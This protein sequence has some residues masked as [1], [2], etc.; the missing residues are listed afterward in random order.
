LALLCMGASGGGCAPSATE[1]SVDGA[2]E[3]MSVDERLLEAQA[4]L[5]KHDVESAQ[6][7]YADII[8]TNDEPPGAAY[9]GKALTDLLLLPGSQAASNVLVD[10]LGATSGIDANDALYAEEGFLYWQV[11]GVP[12]SDDGSYP[13]IRSL[14]S[15]E[16]PWSQDNL[17]SL[18]G[19]F[20]GLDTPAD[21]MMDD[22]VLLA[23]AM[24]Q[25]ENDLQRAL[26]DPDFERLYVPGRTFHYEDLDLLL[27]RGELNLLSSALA[28]T[29]GS[30]Y[31]V[32]AYQH[33][34][35][36]DEAIGSQST[37]R[38]DVRNGWSTSD[39]AVDYLDSRLVREVRDPLRLREARTAFNASLASSVEA[40]R[41]G[42]ESEVDTTIRWN[43]GDRAYAVEL[44]EFLEA[45]RN[46]LYGPTELPGSTP[47]T[48]MDLSS[49]FDQGRSLEADIRWFER[50]DATVDSDDQAGS[51]AFWQMTDAAQQAFFVDGVFEPSFQI[52]EDGAPSLRIDDER[53]RK[54]RQAVTGD[55]QSGVED[56]Y[57]TT[58]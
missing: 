53:G 37:A 15:S 8:A 32:A 17:S 7:I 11:R 19:F 49:F 27:G 29:R 20:T 18:R 56:A 2:P 44:I 46:S 43:E 38:D 30:I 10:H 23:D 21:E 48:V 22:L 31:F 34:W 14:I 9:A 57:F 24:A 25:I 45:L 41:L 5:A 40:I 4:Q 1:A 16:L 26:D 54:F 42:L 36:L 3:D 58:Q 33:D 47:K 35:T 6:A 50:V 55:V 13:G 52:S 39:Y 28:A 51:D 12:W